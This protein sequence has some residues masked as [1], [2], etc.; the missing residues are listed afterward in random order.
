MRKNSN[1]DVINITVDTDESWEY[2]LDVRYPDK[3]CSGETLYNI[4]NL[5]RNGNVCTT[6]LTSDMLPFAGK[7]TM[8]IRGI[9]GDKIQHSDTFEAWVKYSI[10]PGETYNPVP[11][12]FYQI[13]ANIDEMNNHPPYPSDDGYWMI[14]NV[15]THDYEKS[16]I[17]VVAKP[18]DGLPNIDMTTSGKYLSND[19]TKAMWTDVEVE[20]KNAVL[21]TQQNLTETQKQQA[22]DNIGAGTSSFSG[23]YDDLTNKP[24]AYE[25]PIASS[26]QLGGVKPD[27]KID[28]MTQVVGVDNEGKLWFEPDIFIVNIRNAV[29]DKS[30]AEI[31]SAIY[32]GKVVYANDGGRIYPSIGGQGN[33]LQQ[34]AIIT[35]G[36]NI[37]GYSVRG[38]VVT[39]LRNNVEV[40]SNKVDTI[41]STSSY[42]QYPSA[43][44]VYNAIQALPT[45]TDISL[46]IPSA[47]VGDIVKVKAVDESGKPTEW[48]AVSEQYELLRTI[49][50]TEEINAL[51]VMQDDNGNPFSLDSVLVYCDSGIG[52]G[53]NY[54]MITYKDNNNLN[55]VVDN[56]LNSARVTQFTAKNNG[57][58]YW[59]EGF[60]AGSEGDKYSQFYRNATS[61]AFEPINTVKLTFGEAVTQGRIRIWGIKA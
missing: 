15:N 23:S 19:G 34:F 14:Y 31:F 7:Y 36:G 9:N 2:K 60:W 28:D 18:G 5:T 55:L 26:S 37:S 42:T 3:C 59:D 53:H 40:T 35:D 46:G 54:K 56:A 44:C 24:D 13:E 38:T 32:N 4:I 22:R 57:G 12:E 43:K 16:E 52:A 47:V 6:I 39:Q 50:I 48:E 10:E 45:G 1:V 61:K 51:T 25:L 41:S 58:F 49:N 30:S 33:I 21:Y 11:S 17:P 8:Q 29:S 27:D 20:A